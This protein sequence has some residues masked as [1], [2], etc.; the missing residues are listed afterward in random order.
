MNKD[1]EPHQNKLLQQLSWDYALSAEEIRDLLEGKKEKAGHYTRPMLFRKMLE[2]YP[3]F[4]ILKLLPA[5]Q[6]KKL[7]TDEVIGSLRSD[8]L[9]KKYEYIRHRL[10]KVV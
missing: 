4:T 6:V 9:K 5:E 8:S 3:W 1:S 7:L 2:T 10:Q